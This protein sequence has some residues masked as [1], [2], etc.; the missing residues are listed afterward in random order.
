MRMNAKNT[1]SA[2]K[3]PKKVK[4]IQSAVLSFINLT[5]S[6]NEMMCNLVLLQE[7]LPIIDFLGDQG[8]I[9]QSC[10]LVQVVLDAFSLPLYLQPTVNTTIQILTS[11]FMASDNKANKVRVLV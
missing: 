9:Q 4:T 6:I 5:L 2:A 11:P 7:V 10:L 3:V 1:P 8:R